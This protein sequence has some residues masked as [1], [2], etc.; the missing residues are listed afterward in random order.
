MTVATIPE[1]TEAVAPQYRLIQP[2]LPDQQAIIRL[3]LAAVVSLIAELILPVFEIIRMPKPDWLAIEAQG[4]WFILTVTL[5]AGTW[6]PRFPRVWKPVLLLFSAAL[7]ISSGTLAVKGA[8]MAPFLFLLV[9]LPVGGTT[10]P[11]ETRW[12]AGMS[13]ICIVFGLLFAS[14]VGMA[15]RPADLGSL[16]DGRL[17][18]RVTPGKSGR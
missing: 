10:L 3:R 6:H 12:Q 9:L 1:S 4:I 2:E 8:S 17:D 14:L 15:E 11:W 13:A 5:L 18:P 7:I 16:G